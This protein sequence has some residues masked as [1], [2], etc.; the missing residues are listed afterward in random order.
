MIPL[1]SAFAIAFR[2]RQD[3]H[4]VAGS[5]PVFRILERHIEIRG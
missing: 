2:C 4:E 1:Q 3:I 5:F